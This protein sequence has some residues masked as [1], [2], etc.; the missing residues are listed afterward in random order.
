PADHADHG[1]GGLEGGVDLLLAGRGLDEVG[2]GQHANQR[3]P[4]DSGE[5]REFAGAEDGLDVGVA[6]SGAHG[7]DLVVEAL[8]VALQHQPALD[9]DVD[10]P[11]AVGDRGL[12][13]LEP[14]LNR[15]EA[16]R[17]GGG[18]GGDRDTGALEGGDGGRNEGVIDADGGGDDAEAPCP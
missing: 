13:L 1:E 18:D 17:E 11:G 15:G 10:L 5:G 14:G 12:D 4:G 7:P 6:A 9:D 16:V 8:P 2:A 3:G